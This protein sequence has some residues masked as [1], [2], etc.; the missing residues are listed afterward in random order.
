MP[1]QALHIAPPPAQPHAIVRGPLLSA[2]LACVVGLSVQAQTLPAATERQAE[3]NAEASQ[4]V[5]TP[6]KSNPQ[7]NAALNFLAFYITNTDGLSE[8]CAQLGVSISPYT[9]RFTELHA[10]LLHTASAFFDVRQIPAHVRAKLYESARVLLGGSAQ[11]DHRDLTDAC[12][13]LQARGSEI[14]EVNTFARL[15]PDAYRDLTTVPAPQPKSPQQLQ[16]AYARRIVRLLRTNMRFEAPEHVEG[17]PSGT[18]R[19]ELAPVGLVRNIQVV[20]GS[21]LPGFDDAVIRAIRAAE[22]FPKPEEGAIPPAVVFT[23]Y[24]KD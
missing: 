24:L 12:R 7:A 9:R 16:Q 1:T 20:N 5:A 15:L 4:T 23:W 8:N 14:A 19:M 17:N 10:S 18:Y 21:P 3:R 13:Q 11:D 6:A 22:P 2:L